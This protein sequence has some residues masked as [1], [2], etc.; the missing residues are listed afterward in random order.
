[1]PGTTTVA[2]TSDQDTNG[3]L[4]GV[5]WAVTSLTFSF[6]TS[7]SFYGAG[8]PNNETATFQPLNATQQAAAR[9]VLAMYSS[10]TNLTFT[11]VTETSSVHG[12]LR[13]AQSNA[14]STAWAYFP[15]SSQV[16]GDSWYNYSSGSYANPLKGNYA[17]ATFIHEV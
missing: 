4:S 5:K 7:A 3:L 15:H 6:P 2:A 17:F 14:P 10:F 12:D 11:E 8:Y 1:M 16:G 13:F 9:A